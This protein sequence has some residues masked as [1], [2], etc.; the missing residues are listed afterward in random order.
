MKAAGRITWMLMAAVAIVIMAAAPGGTQDRRRGDRGI[1]VYVDAEFRGRSQTFYDDVPYLGGAGFN[2]RISSVRVGRGE[3]WELCKHAN[4]RGECVTVS[5]DEPNLR[6][7]GLHDEVSSM[8]RVRSGYR[9]DPLPTDSYII[10]YEDTNF[11]G[12]ATDYNGAVRDINS[13]RMQSVTIGRGEWE[14]CEGRDFSGRCVRL[15]RSAPDL[16]AYN[17]RDRVASARPLGDDGRGRDRDRDRQYGR[18]WSIVLHADTN[19]RGRSTRYENTDPNVNV[20]ARSVT[21]ERGVWEL[22]EGRNFTG[23][24]VTLSENTAN[25]RSHNLRDRIGS[26][27]P[28]RGERR[29]N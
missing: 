4:Y 20:R 14:L 26:L 28:L 9:R 13:R 6:E 11:R 27:R 18:D 16:R 24:C 5:G 22:C 2:D 3:E 21:I 12:R 23:R 10:F 15:N 29:R 8:R 25:L 7:K 1:T 17:L 19:F